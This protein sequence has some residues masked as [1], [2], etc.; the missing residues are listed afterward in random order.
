MKLHS[1]IPNLSIADYIS[2]IFVIEDGK[3]LP[4]MGFPLIA[5]GYSG[6]AFQTASSEVITNKNKK[7]DHLFLFGQTIKPVELYTT[8]HFTLIAY[9][10]H[11]HILK[12]LFGFNA[13]ELT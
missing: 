12:T 4:D 2:K 3:L 1:V 5:N 7:A 8:G 9:F 6:F 13:N 10:F 11:P